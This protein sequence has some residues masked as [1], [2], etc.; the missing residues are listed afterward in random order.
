[1][2]PSVNLPSDQCCSRIPSSWGD[3]V[4]C[5]V[6]ADL[7]PTL[8]IRRIRV[9]RREEAADFAANVFCSFSHCLLSALPLSP[10]HAAIW[11]ESPPFFQKSSSSCHICPHIAW[12]SSSI[13]FS[14]PLPI[15][16]RSYVPKL[17]SYPPPPQQQHLRQ[18]RVTRSFLGL[19]F[20]IHVL[21]PDN[22]IQS[23]GFSSISRPMT[24]KSLSPTLAFLS[25]LLWTH[26][27]LDI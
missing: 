4:W 25:N 27:Y 21:F 5:V 22:L 17:A 24:S 2:K 14:Y 9:L 26:F 16:T 15:E 3:K 1:M 13:C 11:L 8:W 19:L 12:S 7:P 6:N 10:Q 20:P 18:G 23:H